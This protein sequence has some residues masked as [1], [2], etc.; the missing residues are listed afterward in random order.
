MSD[1]LALKERLG[2]TLNDI[3]LAACSGAMRSYLTE[4]DRETHPSLVAV[5]PVSVRAESEQGTLGNRLSA[6]FVPLASDRAQPLDRLETVAAAC[7]CA[8]AQERQSAMAPWLRP[9]QRRFPRPWLDRRC[10]L[11]PSSEQCAGCG[12]GTW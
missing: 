3:V 4:H 2:V 12:R 5:V 11:A 1:V 7:D 6:M 9:C 10:G 8:K